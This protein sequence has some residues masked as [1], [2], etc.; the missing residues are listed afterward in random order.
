MALPVS[1]QEAYQ[2]DKGESSAATHSKRTDEQ[3]N[4][5]TSGLGHD[6][7][8]HET[9]NATSPSHHPSENR[10]PFH[11]LF[12]RDGD[13]RHTNDR[14]ASRGVRSEI[15]EVVVFNAP[16]ADTSLR[17]LP[18]FETLYSLLS[19]DIPVFGGVMSILSS[20]VSQ[21]KGIGVI[22]LNFFSLALVLS[23]SFSMCIICVYV[24]CV[25]HS[26]NLCLGC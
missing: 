23:V 17:G 1:D 18:S 22:R 6:H 5:Q 12:M 8:S 25:S 14:I 26:F 13:I 20:Q 10:K 4:G 24:T 2:A 11:V 9:V 21:L 15:G 19:P 7:E 3:R 16:S